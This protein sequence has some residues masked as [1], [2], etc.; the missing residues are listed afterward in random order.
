MAAI[1]RALLFCACIVSAA[2][3]GAPKQVAP[4]SVAPITHIPRE[5]LH[6]VAG[7]KAILDAARSVMRADSNVALITV[8]STGMPRVR[9]VKAFVNE[10]DAQSSEKSFTVWIM[11]RLTTRKVDQIRRNPNVTL[12]FNDDAKVTYVSIMGR[13]VIH[14]DP[15]HPEAK[16]LYDQGYRDFFWPEFPKG[17]VMIEVRPRWLEHLGPAIHADTTSWRPQAVAFPAESW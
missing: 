6:R 5:E 14:T 8:D 17:F 16:R 15:N 4:T 2:C 10:R 7:D 9:T 12:Y 3:D 11:T 1:G 13:A